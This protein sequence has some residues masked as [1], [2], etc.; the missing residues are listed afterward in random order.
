MDN[1]QKK[2]KIVTDRNPRVILPNILTII[3]VCIGISSIKFAM[4]QNYALS[5]IAL[6]L[7]SI[8]D[9]LDGRI[10]R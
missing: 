4:D 2:F 6:L 5:I 8:L 10:A 9:T 1:L 7:A 3:G